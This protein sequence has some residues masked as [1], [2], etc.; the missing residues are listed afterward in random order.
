MSGQWTAVNGSCFFCPGKE[1][2]YALLDKE[3]KWQPACWNC[4]KKRKEE[5]NDTNQSTQVREQAQ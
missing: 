1:G 3:G 4:C 2:G 5:K